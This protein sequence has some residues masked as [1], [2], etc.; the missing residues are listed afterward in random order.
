[1]LSAALMKN[2]TNDTG[3][4]FSCADEELCQWHWL[5]FQLRWWRTLPMTLVMLSAA[6]MKNSGYL[7]ARDTSYAFSCTDEELCQWHWLCFQLR[8]WRTLVACLLTTLV[9]TER[10][11]S[12]PTCTGWV[13]TMLSSPPTM[14]A[15]SPR[16]V[17]CGCAPPTPTPQCYQSVCLILYLLWFSE[18]T[19][20]DACI[21]PKVS[22]HDICILQRSDHTMFTQY[23]FL[24]V[25][26]H[27]V[28][29]IYL[30]QGQFT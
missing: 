24:K 8:W 3:Y 18:V 11:L 5:C 29:T 27:N 21:F 19:S 15:P 30:P 17:H 6:Q 14:P 26:L 12:C 13:F 23:I 20:H 7:F 9:R 10:R 22:S 1:M 25:S 28:H 16:S 4:A 2:S